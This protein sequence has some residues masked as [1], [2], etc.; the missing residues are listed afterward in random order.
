VIIES[1][2]NLPPEQID[3]GDQGT[4]S[5][6]V[7][8]LLQPSGLST[9]DANLLGRVRGQRTRCSLRLVRIYQDP[10]DV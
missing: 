2:V 1:V 10:C 9:E 5:S 6:F 8:L 7:D 3:P 4:K